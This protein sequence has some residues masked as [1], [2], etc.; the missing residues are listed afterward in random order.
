MPDTSVNLVGVDGG[1][2]KV[3]AVAVACDALHRPTTFSLIGAGACRVYQTAPGFIPRPF[4][5]QAAEC[6]DR[7]EILSEAETRQGELWVE[8]AAEVVEEVA[9]QIGRGPLLLGICLPGLKTP[10]GRGIS[11][12][13]HGPRIPDYLSALEATLRR[14]GIALA[15]PIAELGSDADYCGLGEQFASEGLFRGVDHAYYL[16]GGTGIAE[17]L[18]LRGDLIPLDRAQAWMQKAWQMHSALGPRFEELVSVRAF[19]RIYA[20]LL[21]PQATVENGLPTASFPEDAALTGESVAVAWMETTAV[22]LAELIF[23]R[24]WT[25]KNG[26]ADTPY[27][28]M[29]YCSLNPDH[30]YRGI[31]LDRVV[32]GQRSGRICADPHRGLLLRRRLESCLA[33]LIGGCGDVGLA[34]RY[35]DTAGGDQAG[36]LRP[37]FLAFSTLPSAAVGAAVAALRAW[38]TLRARG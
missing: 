32:V 20:N 9:G 6:D 7:G 25:V 28:G 3:H 15:S 21:R 26:R 31:L 34:G 5:D 12:I 17:A 18:K 37:G 23:D 10:D 19:N 35:L 33:G 8:A 30:E 22:V 2:T 38:N 36:A 1:A 4:A 29:S 11:R 27:R 24:L 14:R 13:N 16:G